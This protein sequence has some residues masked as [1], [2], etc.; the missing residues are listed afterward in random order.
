MSWHWLRSRWFWLAVCVV[1][2]SLVIT[3]PSVQSLRDVNAIADALSSG[4]REGLGQAGFK[5]PG[6]E[7][8][9]VTVSFLFGLIEIKD[10][11]HPYLWTVISGIVTGGGLG[12]MAWA[13][14]QVVVGMWR[15]T[16][17]RASRNEAEPAAARD[18][19]A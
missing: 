14:P 8:R 16:R 12:V 13:L 10:T 5:G 19:A 11:P 15:R 1:V 18:P 9:R 2:G 6:T 7:S 17:A 3:I 4:I